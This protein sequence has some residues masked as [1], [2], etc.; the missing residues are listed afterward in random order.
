MN[1]AYAELAST[2]YY[3]QFQSVYLKMENVLLVIRFVSLCP[4]MT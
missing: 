4:N 3:M 2:I 1:N